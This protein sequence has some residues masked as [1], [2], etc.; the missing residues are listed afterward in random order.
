MTVKDN[1]GHP[2][3]CF[4]SSK[5]AGIGNVCFLDYHKDVFFGLA[6]KED[7]NSVVSKHE[8]EWVTPNRAKCDKHALYMSELMV[9]IE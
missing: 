3:L 2:P 6:K 1:D 7:C 4:F 8:S 5:G 9:N